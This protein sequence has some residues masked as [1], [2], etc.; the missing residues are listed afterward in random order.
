MLCFHLRKCAKMRP[1]PRYRN[2]GKNRETAVM[3]VSLS[4]VCD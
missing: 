4:L 3:A 2:Y 1:R